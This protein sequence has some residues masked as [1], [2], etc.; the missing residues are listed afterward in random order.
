MSPSMSSR[1]SSS[2]YSILPIIPVAYD[3]DDGDGDGDSDG[4]GVVVMTF[5]NQV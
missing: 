3:G 1:V 4:D 5:F 2:A